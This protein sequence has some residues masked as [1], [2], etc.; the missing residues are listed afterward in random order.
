MS[1]NAVS[2]GI[3]FWD[4]DT[5]HDFMD[6][7]GKLPVPD[8]SSIVPALEKLTHFAVERRIPIVA[9]VD[10]HSP[11]DAEFERFPP[12]CVAGTPGQRKIQATWP[13]GAETADPDKLDEQVRRL[14]AADIPQLIIEKQALDVFTASA[15]DRVLSGLKPQRVFVYGVATEYCVHRAV[16]GLCKRG[17]AV[18]VASDAVKAVG[19]ADGERALAD[20]RQAGADLTDTQTILDDTS[21]LLCL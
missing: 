4:V 9:T 21:E 18:T 7:D 11:D 5:Q 13:A 20:M 1:R 16:L 12:H 17:Y 10:A 8:A 3:L 2:G 15:A 6:Q 19:E 14:A